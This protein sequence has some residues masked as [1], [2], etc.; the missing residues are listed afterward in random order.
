MANGPHGTNQAGGLIRLP[1][2]LD[3]DS[4]VALGQFIARYA[5]REIAKWED[6]VL[7][8]ADG[9]GTYDSLK[10]VTKEVVDQSKITPWPRPR[11]G[12][13]IPRWRT[14]G[15]SAPTSTVQPWPSAHIIFTPPWSSTSARSTLPAI[16]DRT[17]SNRALSTSSR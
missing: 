6:T 3:A 12:S 7:F 14:F 9:T 16:S 2:E 8:I 4:I 15:L 10:G 11:R 1:S 17:S 13:V 5:A